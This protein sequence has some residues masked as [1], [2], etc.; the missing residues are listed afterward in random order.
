MSLYYCHSCN[1]QLG[2]IVPADPASLTGTQYQ[3][4]KFIKHT[5]P[6]GAYPVNSVFDTPRYDDIKDYWLRT[7]ASG[8]VE[9]DHLGRKNLIYFADK[10]TG[11]TL[12]NQQPVASGDAIKVVLP[13][14]EKK[15]H[16]YPV[17]T[18]GMSLRTCSQCGNPIVT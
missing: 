6:T 2:I 16:L 18:T 4:D 12:I 7:T 11:V 3:L 5:A 10:S 17:T 8:A 1:S 15:V 9:V 14:L 13:E